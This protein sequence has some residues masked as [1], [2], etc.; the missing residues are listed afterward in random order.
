VGR[1]GGEVVAEVAL[2]VLSRLA[3]K[4][5]SCWSSLDEY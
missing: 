5:E 3:S 4:V 1:L 2:R